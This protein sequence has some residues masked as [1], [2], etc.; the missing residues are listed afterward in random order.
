MGQ[1][2]VGLSP[3]FTH[4]NQHGHLLRS[5]GTFF[6][7]NDRAKQ[8]NRLDMGRKFWLCTL[9]AMLMAGATAAQQPAEGIPGTIYQTVNVRSEP[10][11]RYEIVGQ[12]AQGDQV[13]VTGR[14]GE[15]SE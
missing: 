4:Q 12:L 13:M 14:S 15:G 6:C 8:N 9:G 3:L 11:A 5:V 10:G 7:Y 2:A 1:K